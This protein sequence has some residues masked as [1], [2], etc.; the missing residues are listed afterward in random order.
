MQGGA[1]EQSMAFVSASEPLDA[2]S[3]TANGKLVF[4]FDRLTQ[5]KIITIQT[6]IENPETYDA[7]KWFKFV[8]HAEMT[9]SVNSFP[10][11]AKPEWYTQVKKPDLMEKEGKIKNQGRAEWIITVKEPQLP[12]TGLVI[13]DTL[14]ENM[15]YIPGSFSLRNMWYDGNPLYREPVIGTDS[16]TGRQTITYTLQNDGGR[17]SEFFTKAFQI[18]Y[19]TK[20]TDPDIAVQK[21]TYVNQA[22]VEALYEGNVIVKDEA[23][24]TV[25]GE[26]GGV[27]DK[28]FNYKQG[29]QYVDWTVAIN[30]ARNDMSA[31]TE[32]KITDQLADYFDYVE[33]SLYKVDAAGTEIP[34]ASDAYIV[35]TVNDRLIVQLPD[36]GSDC[37][38]FKFRTRFNCLAAELDGQTIKNTVSFMGSGKT[39]SKESASINNISFSSSS[40]GAVVRRELRIKKVDADTGAPLTGAKF[41]LYLGTEC[42]AEAESGTDGFAV[43]ENLGSITG[44]TLKIREIQAPDGYK[45]DGTG[46]VSVIYTEENLKTDINGTKYY[47]VEIENNSTQTAETGDIKIQKTNEGGTLLSGAVFGLYNDT[48]CQ[49]VIM[50]RTTV[51]GLAAFS[52][53]AEGTYYLKE[54]SSPA[55]YKVL[56]K[57]VEVVIDKNGNTVE[58]SYDGTVADSYTFVDA[59]AMGSL[60]I[61]KKEKGTEKVLAGAAFSLYRDAQC[62]DRIDSRITGSD[63]KAAFIN[64][65]LGRTYYYRETA[66][67]TGYVL[68]NTIQEITVGSG[69]ETTDLIKTVVMENQKAVGN[70]VVTKVDNSVAANPLAGVVFRLLDKDGNPVLKGD[71]SYYEVTSDDKGIAIFSDIPFGE[72]KITE[73]LGKTGYKVSADVG[74]VVDIVGDNP[75]TIVNSLILCDIKVVKKDAADN[76]KYLSGAKIGLYT[77]NGVQVKTATTDA[78]GEVIFRDIPYGDYY[79]KELAAPDGYKLDDTPIAISAGEIEAYNGNVMIRSFENEKQNGKIRLMK[80]DDSGLPLPGAEF[81]LYD[82]N[83]TALATAKSM[84]EAEALTAGTAEFTG[85]AYGTYYLQETKAPDGYMRDAGIYEVVVNSDD[86]TSL[87]TKKD[88][89]T[90]ELIISNQKLSTAPPLISLKIKKTDAETNTALANATF[91]IYKDGN[92]TGFTAVTGSD[93]IAYFKRISVENDPDASVYSVVE[94]AAPFGYKLNSAAILLGKRTELN[95]YADVGTTPL[96][97]SQIVWA[98]GTEDNATVQNIPIKGSIWITKTGL[99][100]DVL[101][102]GAEF[103]LYE[104]DRTTK[105]VIAGLSNPV[106]TNTFGIAVF[107]NLPCGTYYVKETGAPKGYA[108]NSTETQVVITDETTKQVSLKDTPINVSVSKRA[109]GGVAEIPG[110]VFEIKKKNDTEIVDSWTSTYAPHRILA[111]ALEINVTYV[112][113]E[114]TAPAGYGYM[115]DIEFKVNA[116]GSITATAEKS[117]QTIIARDLPVDLSVAKQDAD[118]ATQLAG[119]KMALYNAQGTQLF[120]FTSQTAPC[121]IPSGLLVAPKTGYLEYTL[122][123]LTAPDGYEVAQP[124]VFA[125]SY[126]GK[127]YQVEENAGNRNY[128]PLTENKLVM[129]D[130]AKKATDIYIRKLDANSGLDLAGAGF[131]I[132][133]ADDTVVTSWISDGRP[134]RLEKALFTTGAIYTLK[135]KSAPTGYLTAE[136][137]QF[138]INAAGEIEIVT[139]NAENVNGDKDTIL[140][141]DREL[142]LKIRKQ[143][144]FGTLLK[145]AVLK[146]SEYDAS[147][148]DGAGR[149]I[150]Q[151]V[152]DNQN[153]YTVLPAW[154]KSDASYI[155][156]ELDAPAGYK[157]AEDII[158]TIAADGTITR[159]DGVPVYNNTIVMEDEEAGLGI[160]KLSIEGKEGLAGSKLMLTS[161]DDPYFT[162]RTW[163]SDGHIKTWELTDFTPGCTYTLTEIEAP[164]GYAYAEP[165]TFM[166]DADD[167]QIYMDGQKIN[168]RTVYIEDGKLELSVSKQDFYDKTELAGA[169]L[170]IYDDAGRLLTAWTSGTAVHMVDTGKMTAGNRDYQEYILR[171]A[172]APS[173]YRRAHDIRFAIDRNGAVYLVTEDTAGI[174]QYTPVKENKLTMYDEPM[175][176][177]RKLN[178]SGEWVEGAKLSIT[179]KDD[180]SFVPITWVT[181]KTPYYIEDGLLTPGVTYVLREEEAPAGYAYAKELTFTLDADGKLLVEGNPVENGKLVMLDYPIAVSVSKQDAAGR[182]ALA[183][184]KLV[185]KNDAGEIIYSFVSGQEKTLLP[186]EIFKTPKPGTLGYYTL[187]ELEAPAGYALAADIAFAIDSAGKLYVRNEQGS[188]DPADENIIVMLD[189]ANGSDTTTPGKGNTTTVKKG[190][191]P[192]T[193]DATPLGLLIVLCVIG[194]TGAAAMFGGYFYKK[195]K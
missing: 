187:C 121:K 85:L 167:H 7:A 77:Q 37:Y 63:G 54:I 106:K 107:N 163:V 180:E 170:E 4:K 118:T 56:D 113:S 33:G 29:N 166:I 32:P 74:I 21:N 165:I 59:K 183:G 95:F 193:G 35:S 176:S 66:A 156:Q 41:E 10:L 20:V 150:K 119:A 182:N 147:K 178:P 105:A 110:A 90:A 68:D 92:P 69:T 135:E 191:I 108:L 133:R 2:S 181:G 134:H 27:I 142:V 101:L 87:Y 86:Y 18:Y 140:I 23:A 98:K 179:A 146:L 97:E 137:V 13:T 131:E 8:N 162:P 116:D 58:V 130:T 132:L 44:Y 139:G 129:K 48:A 173:G 141:R 120:E 123:E 112:L 40:A 43:F 93:G 126:E 152:T 80:T 168:D 75:L 127:I 184:A 171:E 64:L 169:R 124:I 73:I 65:E 159:Q 175:L 177:V 17:E 143:N 25:T 88:G 3:D 19:D 15:E 70:I 194:F 125:V 89:T 117:G 82:K 195:R 149:E 38:R 26:I 94:T 16:G 45:V 36:I 72:Y 55:G 57:I 158:F 154:L 79:L 42:I 114:K 30:E 47:E 62:T 22:E 145:G 103:T 11:S 190:S 52:G 50:T 192:K 5:K 144:S 109:V 174:K 60:Q 83:R 122:K 49:N 91:E 81:T 78:S 96:T 151:F 102:E 172:E 24:A 115:Q 185:I 99:N 67:P 6:R 14:P 104:A 189:T 53:L 51:D 34:V 188:Y 186:P 136:D 164:A 111:G 161:K 160:G 28:T 100:T 1:D 61:V 153:V 9:S 138:T 31:I 84:T 12:L 157:M 76:S 39:Y 155:L 71:G 128:L 46:E 148:P